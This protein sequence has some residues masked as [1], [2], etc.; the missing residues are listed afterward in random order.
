MNKLYLFPNDT[1]KERNCFFNKKGKKKIKTKKRCCA[2]K[3]QGK[4]PGEVITGE[5]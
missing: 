5:I 2:G 4:S 3:F 1:V